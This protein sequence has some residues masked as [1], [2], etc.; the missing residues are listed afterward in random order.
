MIS[1]VDYCTYSVMVDNRQ[2]RC[3]VWPAASDV[4]LLLRG[5]LGSTKMGLGNL[6]LVLG[7]SIGFYVC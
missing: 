4:E 3:W 5:S 1:T 7:F 6:R 2:G